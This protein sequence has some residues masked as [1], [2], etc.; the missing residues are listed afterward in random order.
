MH[1]PVL[2]SEVVADLVVKPGGCY[3]DGTLGGAGHA[4]AVLEKAGEQSRLLG[5][6]R[7]GAA[8][9]LARE[10]L[11]G[12][13]PERITLVRGNFAD[14]K[15]LAQ[16]SGFDRFDGILLDLGVSSMQ[17][18]TPERGFSFQHDAD[19]DMRMDTRGGPTAADVVNG[20][21]EAALADVIWKLGEDRD[22]RRIARQIVVARDRAPLRRT[23]E[24]ADLVARAKG[25]R[26]GRIHPATQTFQALRMTVN[27][28]LESVE[29]GLNAA[30]DLLAPAG[31][32]G[33]ISFHSLE[34]RL[35]KQTLAAHVAREE[36]L[37]QGGVRRVVQEPEM[38]WVVRKPVTA[39]E[40]EVARNPRA[41]SAKWRVVEKA[42]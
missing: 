10:R 11:V 18:D 26:R 36:S 14:M 25:G 41:R 6:D 37:P 7:D 17:L 30:L 19:L 23:G 8:L 12:Y 28:E 39:G 29:Q 4:R 27:R 22:A 15:T 13:G 24:L 34:D 16:Q 33:V 5:L 40:D 32:L 21:E 20:W 2:L 35:V 3:L 1:Q 38:T 42:G 9:E 31:R